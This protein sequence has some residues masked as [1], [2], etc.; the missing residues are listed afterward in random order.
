MDT[1]YLSKQEVENWKHRIQS[2]AVLNLRY[3]WSFLRERGLPSPK[4]VREFLQL[5][6]GKKPGARK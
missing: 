1:L 5:A 3:L 2:T 6:V 4:Q